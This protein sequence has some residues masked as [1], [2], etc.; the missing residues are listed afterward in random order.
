MS[1]AKVPFPVLSTQIGS[2]FLLDNSQSC[3]DPT[4]MASM[5]IRGIFLVLDLEGPRDRLILIAS[6]QHTKPLE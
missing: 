4:F 5:V 2:H 6:P 1:F 3:L